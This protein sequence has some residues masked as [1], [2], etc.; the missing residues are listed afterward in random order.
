MLMCCIDPTAYREFH[1]T[2]MYV[3]PVL[4]IGNDAFLNATGFDTVVFP[5]ELVY[6]GDNA[7][8]N[9]SIQILH[10]GGN[11]NAYIGA[12]AFVYANV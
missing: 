3:A 4:I 6:I 10:F 9:S 7:F 5:P 2:T 8:A 12:N 11:H 1:G